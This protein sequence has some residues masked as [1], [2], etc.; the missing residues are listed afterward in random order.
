[1]PKIIK[2]ACGDA[3]SILLSEKGEVYAFGFSYQGQLGLGIT[4]ESETFQIFEPIKL[5]FDGIKII[6]IFVGSTFTFFKT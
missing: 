6:D 1:M 3:H 4:G 2:S 5:D